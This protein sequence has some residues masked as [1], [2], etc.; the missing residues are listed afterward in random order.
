MTADP[1]IARCLLRNRELRTAQGWAEIRDLRGAL[2]VTSDA[3]VPGLNCLRGFNARER[4]LEAL[5]DVGFALLRAFDRD[6][7]VE[8]SPLDRPRTIRRHV[9]RRGLV[10]AERLAWMT[11]DAAAPHIDVRPEVEV[12]LAGHDDIRTFAAIVAGGA[13]WARRLC[14]ASAVNAMREPGNALYLGCIDGEAVSTLHLLIDGRTAG[15]YA[16]NTRRAQRRQG[17]G[18]TVLARAIADARSAGCGVV[19]L[20]AIAGGPAER[21]YARLGFNR[22]FTTELW[23]VPAQGIDMTG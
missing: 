16:V 21:L 10:R 17:I 7:A 1:E 20:A 5:L 11:R 18:T 22:A 19:G 4:D 9:A 12:R 3:P 2:A 6:P 8:I 23:T 13:P 15:M 14:A